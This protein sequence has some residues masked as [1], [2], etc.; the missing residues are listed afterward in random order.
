MKRMESRFPSKKQIRRELAIL[1]T[2]T[3]QEV[4]EPFAAYVRQLQQAQTATD[5]RLLQRELVFDIN[6]RQK[7]L[8]EVIAEHE[9]AAKERIRELTALEPKPK[10][11]LRAQQAVLRGVEHAKAVAD[12]LQHATRVLADGMVWRALDYD[13]PTIS[14]LGKEQPV[15]RHADDAGFNAELAAIDLVEAEHGLLT[16]HNDTTNILRRGDITSILVENGRPFPLP[17]EVKAGHADAAKQVERIKQALEMIQSRRFVVPVPFE[18][19]IDVLGELIAEAKRT[20]YA[21]AKLDCQFVQVIDYRHFGGREQQVGEMVQRSLADLGWSGAD[22]LILAGMSS[23]SRIRDRGDPVIEL[24]PIS[25]FPLPPED[26]ADLLLGFVDTSVHLNTQLL[27]LRFAQRGMRAGFAVAPDS[28]THFFEARRGYRGFLTPAYVREQMLHELMTVE[29]LTTL[30][31]WI[32]A[33]GKTR[34]WTDINK[35]PILG[36]ESESS[37]WA[38]GSPLQLAA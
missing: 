1:N 28:R 3:Y 31:D 9:P 25:I 16:F 23:V 14:I 10:E 26:V 7:A 15:A 29:T 32:L 36:F 37:V 4:R 22:R 13:R 8:R 12:A 18:T 20:G 30:A 21:K 35:A 19:H 6:G 17:R 27:G 2:P 11:E 24:A 33:S 34:E 5:M 38:P